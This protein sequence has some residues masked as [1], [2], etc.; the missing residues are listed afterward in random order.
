MSVV[1]IY[2]GKSTPAE[3]LTN[4]IGILEATSC[5]V[6]EEVNGAYTVDITIPVG[7]VHSDAFV[8][9][10]IIRASTPKGYDYF[11]LDVPTVTLNELSAKAWQISNALGAPVV[12][13]AYIDAKTG[14]Q[15]LPLILAC[16]PDETRFT[17]TSDI[18][19]VNNMRTTQQSPLGALMNTAVD[20]CFLNRWG[21][22]V[23]RNKFIFNIKN[24]IGSDKGYQIA[25]GKNLLGVTETPTGTGYTTRII[26][27]CLTADDTDLFLPE[28]YINSP[29]PNPYDNLIHSKIYKCEGIKVGA[30][31][32]ETGL[33]PYPTA[34]SA[35]TKMR[36]IVSELY[37]LG[38]DVPGVTI[39]IVFQHLGDTEEYKQF[40][41]LLALDIQLG[42]TVHCTYFNRSLALRVS[43]YWWDSLGDKFIK[44]TIGDIAPNVAKSMYAQDVS[45]AALRSDMNQTIK[46]SEKYNNVYINHTDG[47]VAECAALNSKAVM[48]GEKLGY[49]DLTTGAFLGGM[50]NVAGIVSMIA[51]M[52]TNDVDSDFFMVPGDLTIDS[53]HYKGIFGYLKSFSTTVPFFKILANYVSATPNTHTL[54]IFLLDKFE[55]FMRYSDT[56]MRFITL[57]GKYGTNEA[58]MP[59]IGMVRNPTGTMK[60]IDLSVGGFSGGVDSAGGLY[61]EVGGIRTYPT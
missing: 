1:T 60:S 59:S 13:N 15:A 49:Y 29:L 3:L 30:V 14:A 36:S 33:I 53:L 6:F 31:D 47:F 46:Q 12:L 35:Y 8:F 2:S 4:G 37:A 58:D 7:S 24:R 22:E 52:F 23:E 44:L 57:G 20:N 54:R 26:P 16:S 50:A 34:D 56:G 48:N 5:V 18:T 39:D 43:A 45:L 38:A 41:A 40:K 19:T 42:D 61:K 25:L 17:G 32:T 28:T 10:A 27:K 55:L 21:G 51:K 11:Q 9:G